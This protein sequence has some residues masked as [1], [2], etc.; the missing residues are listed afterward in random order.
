M[1]I[2]LS[3][4]ADE[5]H[6][7]YDKVIFTEE[8]TSAVSETE[9]AVQCGEK[10]ADCLYVCTA[11]ELEEFAY[12]DLN[13][14]VLGYCEAEVKAHYIFLPDS[15][16]NL[17]AVSNVH[18]IINRI[19]S[20]YNELLFCLVKNDPVSD[21]LVKCN[22]I[23]GKNIVL[24]SYRDMRVMATNI[25]DIKECWEGLLSVEGHYAKHTEKISS[26]YMNEKLFTFEF[27][28]RLNEEKSPFFFTLDHLER[29]EA[30]HFIACPLIHNSAM[31]LIA[32]PSHCMNHANLFYAELLFQCISESLK[33]VP[34]PNH[35]DALPVSNF[36]KDLVTERNKN[37]SDMIYQ[38][39]KMNWYE[40]EKYML[41][42]FAHKDK[43][44]SISFNIG[45]FLVSLK[46]IFPDSYYEIFDNKLAC[47]VHEKTFFSLRSDVKAMFS[48]LLKKQQ[49]RCGCSKE[50]FK[51]DGLSAYYTQTEI[52][53]RYCMNSDKYYPVALYEDKISKHTLGHFNDHYEGIY[54]IHPIVETLRDYDMK[55]ESDLVLTLYHYL[56][57]ERSYNVTANVL[58]ISKSTLHYR[59]NKIRSLVNCDFESL[60]K[61]MNL[62]VSTGI[63][64][65]GVKAY[66]LYP[67]SM[68][69]LAD[70]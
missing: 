10:K 15:E 31:L 44:K 18:K 11:K 68:I 50:F 22:G 65:K 64:I 26:Y 58:N 29:H 32:D 30:F 61:R 34:A 23:L 7:F 54:F 52:A 66:E 14:V 55:T 67:S 70:R 69:D 37:K 21:F 12:P 33:H 24:V 38:F 45:N 20:W 41:M 13:Y 49:L 62:L 57:C 28:R 53:L 25:S 8:N 48:D 43:D 47:I 42:T 59:L 5:L 17:E 19:V 60:D 51:F 35:Q 40:D 16:N 2:P 36:L 1:I 63:A 9:L 27:I 6:R 46:E 39:G 4:I 56:I 3:V